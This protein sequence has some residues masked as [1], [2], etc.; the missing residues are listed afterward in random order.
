MKK[1]RNEEV[2]RKKRSTSE[3][4]RN[5]IIVNIAHITNILIA[6]VKFEALEGTLLAMK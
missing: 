3:F 1:R 4:Q 2:K 5:V 6:Q